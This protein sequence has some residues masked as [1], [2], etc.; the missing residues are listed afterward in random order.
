M[1]ETVLMELQDSL[2]K[3]YVII[4]KDFSIITVCK[5]CAYC[6]HYCRG[7]LEILVRMV[8]MAI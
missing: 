8:L 1:E 2:E 4:S 7:P 5:Y 3:W 6:C